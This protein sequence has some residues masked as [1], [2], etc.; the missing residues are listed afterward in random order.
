MSV[1]NSAMTVT[2]FSSSNV[3]FWV[4]LASWLSSHFDDRTPAHPSS[5]E[6]F[7][8]LAP[9]DPSLSVFL[10]NR[11]AIPTVQDP[12]LESHRQ[13]DPHQR[14]GPSLVLP[15]LPATW[16]H[17]ID[18][19][20]RDSLAPWSLNSGMLDLPK[21][22]PSSRSHWLMSGTA[23]TQHPPHLSLESP[24]GISP[25]VATPPVLS[26]THPSSSDAVIISGY[27]H[28]SSSTF[29]T[30]RG[31]IPTAQDSSAEEL[32]SQGK[33]CLPDKRLDELSTATPSTG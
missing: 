21:L 10:K 22:P 30:N 2:Y 31:V 1:K 12:V 7:V 32:R 18:A 8:H 24:P 16:L 4:L 5:P 19:A 6:A 14:S 27:R 28:S 11:E 3:M 29:L 15:R 20:F 26:S 13:T 17:A 9:L 33:E 25:G 23:E